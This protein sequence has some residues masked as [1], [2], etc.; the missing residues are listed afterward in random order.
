M[1]NILLYIYSHFLYIQLTI[2]LVLRP[3]PA[4]MWISIFKRLLC[5]RGETV[6]VLVNDG[7]SSSS[8]IPLAHMLRQLAPMREGVRGRPGEPPRR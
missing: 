4:S 3:S 8:H 1:N 2:T 5:S 6:T 7:H